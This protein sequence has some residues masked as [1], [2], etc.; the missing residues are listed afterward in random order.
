MNLNLKVKHHG[1][2]NVEN[3]E[4]SEKHAEKNGEEF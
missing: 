1:L 2:T 4:E 3:E